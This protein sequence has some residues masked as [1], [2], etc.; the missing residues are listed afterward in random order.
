MLLF[1]YEIKLLRNL[2]YFMFFF[3]IQSLK[4]TVSFI[5]I[6]ISKLRLATFKVLSSN[7]WLVATL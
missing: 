5:L 4:S 6:N 1:L 2:R 3:D 7:V